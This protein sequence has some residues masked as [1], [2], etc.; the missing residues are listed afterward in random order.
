MTPLEEDG[1]RKLA[2]IAQNEY[3]DDFKFEIA[4]N[5]KIVETWDREK[6]MSH[7]YPEM[8]YNQAIFPLATD[9]SLRGPV[10]LGLR[11]TSTINPKQAGLSVTHIYWV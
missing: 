6:F 3:P 4:V 5:G 1:H 8:A 11:V 10:E 9:E 7:A 2:T